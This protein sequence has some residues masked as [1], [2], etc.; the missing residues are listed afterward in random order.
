MVLFEALKQHGV[1]Y[2]SDANRPYAQARADRSV[3]DHIQY[4][5]E[6]LHSKAGDCNDLTT[7][8]CAPLENAGVHTALVDDPRHIFMLFD[9]GI[10]PRQAFLLPVDEVYYHVWGDRLW[11]PVE[12]T[13]VDASFQAAWRAGAQ[14]LSRLKGLEH[15]RRIVSTAT[16]WK[17]YAATNPPVER[18]DYGPRPGGL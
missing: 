11:I 3:V 7:L 17:A 5:A 10:D 4:P 14:R 1:R 15:R 12:T 2:V 13:L 16:A 8:Y 9:T 18:T 6:L